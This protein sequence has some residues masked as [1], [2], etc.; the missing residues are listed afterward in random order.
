MPFP[1]PPLPGPPPLSSSPIKKVREVIQDGRSQITKAREDIHSL[2][3]DLRGSVAEESV[4][5]SRPS[6]STEPTTSTV[7]HVSED[8]TLNYQLDLILDDLQHL[9][10]EHLPRQGR[11]LG[12]SCDCISKSARDL[13]RHSL[14]TIPIAARQGV[15]PKLFSEMANVANHLVQI[16]TLSA[17][18]SGKYDDEY[19]QQAGV[20]SAFRKQVNEMMAGHPDT[21]EHRESCPRCRE[22]DLKAFRER[23]KARDEKSD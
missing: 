2:A 17:V 10:T 5:Q 13:R 20:M 16:G 4:P 7:P 21:S 3:S 22:L 11:I 19:L 6:L 15:S 1:F 18:N 9:E 14:E 23:Q 8:A 12:K